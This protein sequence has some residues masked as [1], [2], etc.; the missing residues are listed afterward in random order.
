MNPQDLASK[1]LDAEID[2][3]YTRDLLDEDERM[4]VFRTD[5]DENNE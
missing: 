5:A 4:D 3:E 1:L 2:R